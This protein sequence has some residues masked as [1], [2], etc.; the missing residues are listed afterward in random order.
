MLSMTRSVIGSGGFFEIPVIILL[1]GILV[2]AWQMYDSEA[3]ETSA[4][5]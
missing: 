1:S 4:I 3:E 2:R 5:E